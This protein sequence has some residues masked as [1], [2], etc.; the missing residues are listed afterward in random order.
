MEIDE[1]IELL[2]VAVEE[3]DW[4]LVVEC[5]KKME[6]AYHLNDGSLDTYFD[7]SEEY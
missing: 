5:V 7:K 4:D 1:I 3:S 6:T 2:N